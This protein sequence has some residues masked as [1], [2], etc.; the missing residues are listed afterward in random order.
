MT[1]SGKQEKGYF[2]MFKVV[3]FYNGAYPKTNLVKIGSHNRVPTKL[4]AWLIGYIEV[5][6][7]NGDASYAVNL[8]TGE[9]APITREKS[10]RFAL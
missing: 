4:L 6:F 7:C 2:K 10:A 3:T 5:N 8:K 9:V 1:V